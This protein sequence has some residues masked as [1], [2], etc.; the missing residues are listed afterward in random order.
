MRGPLPGSEQLCELGGITP[1]AEIRKQ[2][3]RR[4]DV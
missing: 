2:A 4:L 1:F 3:Q